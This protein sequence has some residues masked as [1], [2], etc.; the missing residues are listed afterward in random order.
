MGIF[1]GHGGM[2]GQFDQGFFIF[3]SKTAGEFVDQFEGPE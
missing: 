2:G 3:N 1:Q